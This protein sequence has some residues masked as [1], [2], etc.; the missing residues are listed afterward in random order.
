MLCLGD[1]LG[2][3]CLWW[4]LLLNCLTDAGGVGNKGIFLV[5]WG[6]GCN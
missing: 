6:C 4:F 5:C 1:G 3:Y 2:V